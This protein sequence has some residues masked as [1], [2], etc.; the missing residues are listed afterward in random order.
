MVGSDTWQRDNKVIKREHGHMRRN[1]WSEKPRL[2]R[3]NRPWKKVV[4]IIESETWQSVSETRANAGRHGQTTGG[5]H[6][7]N[8]SLE[9]SH[10]NSA[11]R[12][13]CT[14]LCRR[15]QTSTFMNPDG[16]IRRLQ[17]DTHVI[18][19]DRANIHPANSLHTTNPHPGKTLLKECHQPNQ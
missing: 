8:H 9:F 1:S 14:N 3:K 16:D 13:T 5:R 15:C 7:H 6:R 11:P 18:D 12:T 4:G 10:H 19:A 17:C 2:K